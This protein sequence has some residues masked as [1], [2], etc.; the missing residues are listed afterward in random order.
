[1]NFLLVCT[2]NTCRSSMGE[3]LLKDLLM[4]AGSEGHQVK[5]AGISAFPGG[6]AAKQAIKVMNEISLDL[7]SHRTNPLTEDLIVEAD[8]ILTMTQRHKFFIL[9]EYPQSQAKVYT[10]KEYS[11]KVD[12]VQEETNKIERIYNRIEEKRHRFI[13]EH[14]SELEELEKKRR[15]LLEEIKETEDNI[16]ELENE[17]G[18]IILPEQRE[19]SKLKDNMGNLDIVDPFGQPSAIYRECAEEIKVELEKIVENLD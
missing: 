19:L 10:L 16:K 3:V 2:G 8:C 1:M 6:S 13:Q 7:G 5:S 12:D 11:A 9:D 18:E 4:K 14:G 17:L 15:L